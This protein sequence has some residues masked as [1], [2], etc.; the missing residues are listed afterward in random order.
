MLRASYPTSLDLQ[1][2]HQF[3]GVPDQQQLPVAEAVA[4]AAHSLEQQNNDAEVV[5]VDAWVEH[6]EHDGVTP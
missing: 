4:V 3:R 2:A 6:E 1:L 5:H